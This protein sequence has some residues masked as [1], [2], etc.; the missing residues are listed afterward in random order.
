MAL[1]LTTDIRLGGVAMVPGLDFPVTGKVYFVDSVTGSNGNDG[2]SKDR[3][4][5]T[6]DYAVGRCTASKGDVIVVLPGH[7]ETVTA[8]AGLDLDV[9]GITIVGVG[10]GRN[11]P[12][13]NFTTATTADMDVDAANIT[14][15]NLFFDMT[16]IDALAAGIDV[17]SADFTM[18][19]C[20]VELADASG[21]CVAG[22]VYDDAADRMR[23]EGCNFHGAG[24]TTALIAVDGA[25]ADDVVIKGNIFNGYFGTTGAVQQATTAGVNW[26]IDGN[27]F[28]N[29]TADA[30][31]LAVNLHASTVAL[32]SNNRIAVIDSTSPMPVVA[33]AGFVSGNYFKG[34]VGTGADSDL[35]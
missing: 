33:A 16:S 3:P 12:K 21:Q 18:L 4:F 29:R 31:N 17:N 27:Y 19:N 9:A 20:E 25:G 13:I 15:M 22:V 10:N 7:V 26:V 6:I 1:P 14:I 35:L 8:A 23:I 24:D 28:I 11:R 34:A 30:N 2:E 5:A 32:I